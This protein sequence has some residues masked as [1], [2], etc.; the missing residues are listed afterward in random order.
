MTDRKL[1]ALF[2][3]AVILVGGLL[4]SLALTF[5]LPNES[6][7][8]PAKST[9]QP[10]NPSSSPITVS[11]PA[12]NLKRAKRYLE[13]PTTRESIIAAQLALRSIPLSATEYK[14]A[15]K[16]LTRSELDLKA[17]EARV[18][19]EEATQLRDTLRFDYERL[20]AEANPHL[21]YIT[22]KLSKHKSGF[23]LWGVHTY[24]S[25][26]TFSIGDDAKVVSAWIE[27]NQTDL[28]KAGILRVGVKS[29]ESW[30]GSC[31]FDL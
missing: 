17:V 11:A 5:T 4:W 23:A 25:Q 20:L 10:S 29:R 28:K 19:A 27:K 30:S 9:A 31:W 21:N 8:Q 13:S 22:A 6:A 16:L 26:Y 2:V 24:F 15:Q 18:K 7:P 3:G 1:L 14:E 12:E